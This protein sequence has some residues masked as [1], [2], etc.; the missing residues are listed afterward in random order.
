MRSSRPCVVW[1]FVGVRN[2]GGDE[3]AIRPPLD[4]SR[5]LRLLI[6]QMTEWALRQVDLLDSGW[7]LVLIGLLVAIMVGGIVDLILDA[8]TTLL[9]FHSAFEVAFVL[10]CLGTA[11][12]LWLAG[13]QAER[14]LRR[15]R[16]SLASHESEIAG[17][18]VYVLS[19]GDSA[20][21]R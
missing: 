17:L 18:A 6:R 12:F 4:S 2:D 5:V 3:P 8:P 14:S 1:L 21:L 13:S 16:E 9:S 19:L 10:L 20:G 7:Q 15:T 11:I